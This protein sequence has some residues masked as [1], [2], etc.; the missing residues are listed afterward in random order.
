VEEFRRKYENDEH[1]YETTVK[2]YS[3]AREVPLPGDVHKSSA[4]STMAEKIRAHMSDNDHFTCILIKLNTE[5]LSRLLN[6][7]KIHRDLAIELAEIYHFHLHPEHRPEHIARDPKFKVDGKVT[8]VDSSARKSRDGLRADD[9]ESTVLDISFEVLVDN[10]VRMARE[11]L[12][13]VRDFVSACYENA[14]AAF[15][16]NMRIPDPFPPQSTS[17]VSYFLPHTNL[18]LSS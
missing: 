8:T 18:D 5:S 1:V 15:R 11:S 17:P 7:N 12:R 3:T 16:C 9:V 4:F 2:Q 14:T 6:E 13:G 10:D